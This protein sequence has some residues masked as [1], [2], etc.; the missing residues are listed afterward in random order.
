[1]SCRGSRLDAACTV[2]LLQR[3]CSMPWSWGQA[4]AVPAAR[5]AFLLL[6]H[7]THVSLPAPCKLP[8]CAERVVHWTAL[9]K[10]V[11]SYRNAPLTAGAAAAAA[12]A[13]Q[14]GCCGDSAVRA[15][16]A[17]GPRAQPRP[18]PEGEDAVGAG[19]CDRAA[20]RQVS[21]PGVVW[22]ARACWRACCW[23]CA[24]LWFACWRCCA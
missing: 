18:Q 19:R 23:C 20:C 5:C 14:A 17:A 12:A 11:P 24:W 21:R 4:S 10:H 16:S 22:R 15:G 13:P 3:C 6:I 2:R 9:G 8:T 7:D 1:M